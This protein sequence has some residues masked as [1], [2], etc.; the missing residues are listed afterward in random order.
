MSI[1]SDRKVSQVG[2]FRIKTP[3]YEVCSYHTHHLFAFSRGQIFVKGI[4]RD[5]KHCFF[6]EIPR[7]RI[8]FVECACHYVL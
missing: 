4:L 5:I 2:T 1:K 7:D 8:K 3:P 6:S